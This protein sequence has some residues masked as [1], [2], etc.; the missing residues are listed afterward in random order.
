MAIISSSSLVLRQE[1]EDLELKHNSTLKQLMR[2]SYTAGTKG[3]G[4]GNDHKG[5]HRYKL[6]NSI[7]SNQNQSA[8]AIY[9][10]SL[11]SFHIVLSAL[12]NYKQ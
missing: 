9:N 2:V 3:T 7:K 10:L 8:V 1:Q 11:S 4:T 12:C 5:D 6:L